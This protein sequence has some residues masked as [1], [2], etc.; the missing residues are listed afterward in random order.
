M[1]YRTKLRRAKIL[2]VSS[3][4]Y[5]DDAWEKR[6]AEKKEKSLLNKRLR[7]SEKKRKLREFNRALVWNYKLTHPCIRCPEDDPACLQFHHRN[8]ATKCFEIAQGNKKSTRVLEME[9]A[10]C[11]ML[12][13]NCHSKLHFYS[14]PPTHWG[15]GVS[16]DVK[17]SIGLGTP[18]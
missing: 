8:A 13:A 17:V 1:N 9:I 7:S 12:C 18:I 2:K 15:R 3:K 6:N 11:D 5:T 10:K 16:R 4:L 14:E